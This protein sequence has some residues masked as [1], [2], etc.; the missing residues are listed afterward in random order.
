MEDDTQLLNDESREVDGILIE[1][2]EGR[3]LLKLSYN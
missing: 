2:I 1:E 3:Y